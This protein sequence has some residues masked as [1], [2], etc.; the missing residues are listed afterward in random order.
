MIPLV[1]LIS[2]FLSVE[3]MNLARMAG[4]LWSRV[5]MIRL[6]PLVDYWG[7]LMYVYIYI[8]SHTMHTSES[9]QA[10]HKHSFHMQAF[11]IQQGA[12]LCLDLLRVDRSNLA[13]GPYGM[14]FEVSSFGFTRRCRRCGWHWFT[15]PHAGVG[16]RVQRDS[17]QGWWLSSGPGLTF[18]VLGMVH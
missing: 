10:A 11:M 8:S 6:L 9:I 15:N 5:G 12:I 16:Q 7:I 1:D 18:L 17:L 2:T 3:S 13:T 4:H 14:V